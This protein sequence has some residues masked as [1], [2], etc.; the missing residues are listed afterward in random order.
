MS[1]SGA[2][3]TPQTQKI[4]PGLVDTREN[5][6]QVVEL[7]QLLAK[8]QQRKLAKRNANWE[9]GYDAERREDER[10]KDSNAKI[11][12]LH[13]DFTERE[14]TLYTAFEDSG[15]KDASPSRFT[16]E[17]H[18]QSLTRM[19]QELDELR[20]SR[21]EL[22]DQKKGQEIRISPLASEADSLSMVERKAADDLTDAWRQVDKQA[23]ELTAVQKELDSSQDDAAILRQELGSTIEEAEDR[24]AHGAF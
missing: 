10:L 1:D 4:S 18:R 13:T 22:C 20:R 3:L 15:R 21:D 23:S 8:T 14:Q 9:S 24:A 5:L 11:G 6:A 2:L 12:R 17:A 7:Q 16:L 19:R